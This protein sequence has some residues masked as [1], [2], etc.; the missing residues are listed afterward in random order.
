MTS[1]SM[2]AISALLEGERKPS[3]PRPLSGPLE[4]L[5]QSEYCVM[6]ARNNHSVSKSV[7]AMY[8]VNG[9]PLCAAHAMY[10][11]SLICVD[12]G[13][14]VEVAGKVPQLPGTL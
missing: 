10:K 2:D 3:D 7:T 5:I 4:V 9:D 1:L 8:T 11:L 14:K 13:Y 6:C 12:N